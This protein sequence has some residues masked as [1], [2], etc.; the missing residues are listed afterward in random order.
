MLPLGRNGGN[1]E[2]KKLFIDAWVV[3]NSMLPLI[4]GCWESRH[5]AWGSC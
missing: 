5:Q 4:Y 2:Q 1:K 3:A